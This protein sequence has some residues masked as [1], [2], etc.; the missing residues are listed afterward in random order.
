MEK[1]ARRGSKSLDKHFSFYYL[2]G[3]EQDL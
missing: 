2:D 1:H 3:P